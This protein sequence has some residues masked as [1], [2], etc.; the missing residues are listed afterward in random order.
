MAF[1]SKQLFSVLFADDTNMFGTDNDL[2][3]LIVN[4]NTE[5]EKIVKW[6]NA[7]KLSLNI[8][9]THYMLFRNKGKVVKET[10]KVYMN[11]QEIS[12]VETTKF[13]GVIIDNRLNWKHHIDSICNKVS[14]NIGIILTARRVFNKNTLLSLYYSFIYPYF[15]YCIHVWGSAYKTRLQKLQILQK[16]IIRIISGVPPRSLTD[17]LYSDLKIL[18][19]N[20]LYIYYVALFMYKLTLCKLPNIFPMFE[21]NSRVHNYGTRQAHHYHLPLCR[22]NLIK[23][24][25]TFQGPQIWNELVYNIDVDC[26]VSTFQSRLKIYIATGM[27]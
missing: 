23:M 6:L 18:K 25:L 20:H 17:P 27:D 1:V 24:S 15:T 12:E 7:N 11:R 21:L 3:A 19:F 5:L 22:T 14:K 13:L 26:A 9:K 10:C 16:K 2:E 8:E 4:V